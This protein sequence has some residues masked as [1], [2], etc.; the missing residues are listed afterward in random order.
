[1]RRRRAFVL[2]ISFLI[3]LLLGIAFTVVFTQPS[4]LSGVLF[5]L[6][7]GLSVFFFSYFLLDERILGLFLALGSCSYLGL[8]VLRID[9]Y[10]NVGL[11]VLV[12]VLLWIYFKD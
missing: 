1:M 11:L 4:I 7:L 12:L 2:R 3:A 8:R 9:S 10:L 6:L 5:F